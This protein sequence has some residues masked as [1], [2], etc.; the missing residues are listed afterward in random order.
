MSWDTEDSLSQPDRK[1]NEQM[2]NENPASV[3]FESYGGGREGFLEAVT[4]N[5][6]LRYEREVT[7]EGRVFQIRGKR[8]RC[9]TWESTVT[10]GPGR[11]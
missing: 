7:R 4:P 2:D 10:Q 1:T 5:Q 8:G 9:R 3:R 6:V 11:C